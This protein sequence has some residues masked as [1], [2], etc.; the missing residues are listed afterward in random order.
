[1]S[2]TEL[3]LMSE[4]S[5]VD[6]TDDFE[7]SENECITIEF[8][9]SIIQAQKELIE[10]LKKE[11]E[12]LKKV[13]NKD[14]DNEKNMEKIMKFIKILYGLT[15][16]GYNNYTNVV[17]YGD[18]FENFFSRKSLENTKLYFLFEF[19]NE[20]NIRQIMERLDDMEYIQNSDFAIKQRI[21]IN[22]NQDMIRINFWSLKIKISDNLELD[23][24]FHD[25][26]YTNK[27]LFDSQK[28]VL[29]KQGFNIREFTENDRIKKNKH[30]S[31]SLLDTFNNLIHNKVEI[32]KTYNDLDNINEKYLLFDTINEQ[33]QYL[34]RGYEIKKGY[35]NNISKNEESCSICYREHQEEDAC[36]YNL[37]C[38]HI[39]CSDCLYRHT[40]SHEQNNHLNCPLCRGKIE[41]DIKK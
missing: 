25:S 12:L 37:K 17:I 41:L 31:M 10:E 14:I 18:L 16:I 22:R 35:S 26:T 20:T 36:L 3:E 29:T 5:Q 33:N 32:T 27:I 7:S 21:F 34:S 8:D 6:Y 15:E 11:N 2:E 23:F 4:T 39:F 30:T 13:M 24:R 1:M 38:S 28:L 9:N 19:M 40:F